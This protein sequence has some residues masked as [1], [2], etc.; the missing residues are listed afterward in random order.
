MITNENRNLQDRVEYQCEYIYN[1]L[2]LFLELY[3]NTDLSNNINKDYLSNDVLLSNQF[4]DLLNW[5]EQQKKFIPMIRHL[6]NEYD[7][8][9]KVLIDE[10]DNLSY[11]YYLINDS[12]CGGDCCK[13]SY[14]KVY[15]KFRISA[16]NLVSVYW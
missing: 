1:S 6:S 4:D 11:Y 9:Y 7:D 8:N 15:N 2:N 14:K 5:Y 10:M 3:T 12:F 16:D 13:D